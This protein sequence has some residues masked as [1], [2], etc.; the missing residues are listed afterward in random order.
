MAGKTVTRRLSLPVERYG[1]N[2]PEGKPS[3]IDLLE[4]TIPVYDKTGL[5]VVQALRYDMLAGE[6]DEKKPLMTLVVMGGGSSDAHGNAALCARIEDGITKMGDQFP[7]KP[8]IV[9]LSHVSGAPRTRDKKEAVKL[10]K[11]E[12]FYSPT[13]V[14][15]KALENPELGVLWNNLGLIGYFAGGTQLIELAALLGEKCRFIA[16]CDPAGFA[17]HPRLEWEFSVGSV[18]ATVE[19]YRSEGLSFID[20][21]KEAS[22]EMGTAW[23]IHGKGAGSLGKIIIDMIKPAQKAVTTKFARTYGFLDERAGVGLNVKARKHDSTEEAR[24]KITAK[25]VFSP[26]LYA[27]VVNVILEKLKDKYLSVDSLR[28]MREDESESGKLDEQVNDMLKEMFSKAEGV[29]FKPFDDI[30]HSSVM[31]EQSYWD[32]LMLKLKNILQ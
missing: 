9:L 7:V 3:R 19:K 4:V 10:V 12:T 16:L 32:N 29:S 24:K 8:R 11:Q 15:M 30:T 21:L 6:E 14:L 28:K 17:E 31:A 27:K 13:G 26:V 23:V 2:R 22:R 18:L 20:A 25:V 1:Y 5:Y